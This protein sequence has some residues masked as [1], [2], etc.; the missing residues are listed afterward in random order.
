MRPA[1]TLDGRNK[2]QHKAAFTILELLVTMA[3]ISV[4]VGLVFPAV[5][6]ARE[7]ARKLQ[8]SNNLKQI[9][10]ALHSHHEVAGR[11]PCGWTN[12][13]SGR[14]AWGWAT[15]LLPMLEQSNLAA[16]LQKKKDVYDQANGQV[17][18]TQLSILLCPSDAGP[19]H[20]D[21]VSDVDHASSMQ[22]LN[23][24]FSLDVG[25][26]SPLTLPRANYL[27]IFGNHDPDEGW[28][29]P[30]TG[31]FIGNAAIRWRDLTRGLSNVAII[32]E[33]TARRLPSTWIGVALDGEDAVARL[34][35]FAD[36]GP[37]SP[38]ADECE[39]DSRHPGGINVLFAD[40]HV[41][42]VSDHVDRNVYRT[43]ARRQ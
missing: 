18:R 33:R 20:F 28:Q 11:L 1:A 6:Q 4:L 32:G 21:L 16:T 30:G 23:H 40:G 27:G 36:L 8:C 24:T 19:P 37:N 26:S 31:T 13:P 14:S 43:M 25:P 5:Q 7:G 42:H 2:L 10:L 29:T 38:D 9:G 39:M 3:V 41:Q 12:A 35:A 17:L 22:A 15:E 34:T